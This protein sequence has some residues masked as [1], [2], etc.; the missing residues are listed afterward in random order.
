MIR[1]DQIS[2]DNVSSH[3]C[4]RPGMNLI[5]ENGH[6]IKVVSLFDM[7]GEPVSNRTQVGTCDMC[8]AQCRW[9]S[10]DDC[11]E[12]AARRD[13]VGEYHRWREEGRKDG[14]GT[15]AS[16]TMMLKGKRLRNSIWGIWRCLTSSATSWLAFLSL[17]LPIC[18]TEFVLILCYR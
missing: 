12:T 9:L 1:V 17:N 10:S 15:T 3:W 7:R 16:A 18:S 5:S 2:L 6:L 4:C 13:E 8:N 11:Y 14:K